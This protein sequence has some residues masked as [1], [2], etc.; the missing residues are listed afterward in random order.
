MRQYHI[1]K[2]W[3]KATG[4]FFAK[5]CQECEIKPEN[6]QDKVV[7]GLS[8]DNMDFDVHPRG[9]CIYKYVS[10][11]PIL[12]I[13]AELIRGVMLTMSGCYWHLEF[14]LIWA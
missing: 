10:Y 8:R 7:G 13:L 4:D 6:E 12:F 11:M 9:E 1:I 5:L 3:Q 14:G 2:Q